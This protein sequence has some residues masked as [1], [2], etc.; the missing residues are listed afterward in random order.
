MRLPAF[1]PAMAV[2]GV[3][4]LALACGG[5]DDEEAAP[6]PTQAAS[7][8]AASPTAATS[9]LPAPTATASAS[10][11]V[12]TPTAASAPQS[13]AVQEVTVTARETGDAYVFDVSQT[14][15][16]LGRVRITLINQG[17]E[18]PHTFVVKGLDGNTDLL[19]ISQIDP[20]NRTTREF[21][22]TLIRAALA[23]TRRGAGEV[24]LA[25]PG[26][27]WRQGLSSFREEARVVRYVDAAP[28]VLPVY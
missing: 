28:Q 23:A 24:T 26:E 4:A 10:S 14:T 16:R 5:G 22:I 20:G 21:E 12:P 15:L 8:P 17:P 27:S 13:P 6:R 1:L 25:W 2:A 3:I 18:R 9:S 11:P 19:N 7:N